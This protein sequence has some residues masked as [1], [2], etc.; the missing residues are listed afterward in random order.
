MTQQ[1]ENKQPKDLPILKFG[2]ELDF[3]CG[4]K[5]QLLSQAFNEKYQRRPPSPHGTFHSN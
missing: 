4:D 5:Q 2:E 1:K 3:L